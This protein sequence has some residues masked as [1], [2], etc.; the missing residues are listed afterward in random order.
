MKYILDKFKPVAT[1]FRPKT[2]SEVFAL[3][4]AQKLDDS[5]ATRHYLSLTESHSE[6]QLLCAYRR[7]FQSSENGDRGRRFHMELE[8]IHSNGYHNNHSSLISIRV[9]RRTVA[10]AIFTGDHLEYTDSRQLSSA[11][12]RALS[13]AVGFTNWMLE[14]FSVESAVLELPPSDDSFQRK[15][16]HDC[17]HGTLRER[18]LP[19]WEIER[20]ELLEG[21]GHPQLKSRRELREIATQIWPVIAGTHAQVFIQDAAIL[22]LHVQTERLF[23]IN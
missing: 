17:I 2:V 21:Y 16:L 12:E 8:R 18:F 15:A 9:E 11:R 13:S 14:R 23:I 4:L 20:R 6:T 10:A 3:R 1:V 7:T 5:P 22:G 19:I